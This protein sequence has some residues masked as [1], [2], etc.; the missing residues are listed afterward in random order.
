MFGEN[1][2]L[3]RNAII[4]RA[5]NDYKNCVIRGETATH[6]FIEIEGF[7]TSEY[8][9]TLLGNSTVT[10]ADILYNLREWRRQAEKARRHKRPRNKCRNQ[11]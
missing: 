9:G 2:L 7:F 4:E 6:N 5:V 8:C 11:Y 1:L 10:G 3:L